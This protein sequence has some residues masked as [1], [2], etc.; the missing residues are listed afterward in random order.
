MIAQR[1]WFV[2]NSIRV[3]ATVPRVFPCPASATTTAPAGII[4]VLQE[5]KPRCVIQRSVERIILLLTSP[6][7]IHGILPSQSE[8]SFEFGVAPATHCAKEPIDLYSTPSGHS[9]AI[10]SAR[11]LIGRPPVLRRSRRWRHAAHADA[12]RC[13]RSECSARRCRPAR[14]CP[15]A[16]RRRTPTGS[17]RCP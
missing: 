4:F 11:R 5:S 1:D 12:L 2:H 17:S 8:G 3:R 15:R 9:S 14:V 13:R 10:R 7:L 16:R 6:E